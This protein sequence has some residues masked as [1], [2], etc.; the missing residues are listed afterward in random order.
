MRK[1]HKA[2][3]SDQPV[4]PQ[5]IFDHKGVPFLVSALRDHRTLPGRLNA[6]PIWDVTLVEMEPA[7]E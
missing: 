2:V 5:V 1:F 4:V 7:G 3:V 6:V